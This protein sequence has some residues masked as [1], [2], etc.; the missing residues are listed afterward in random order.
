MEILETYIAPILGAVFTGVAFSYMV[1]GVSREAL[2][3]SDKKW[4]YYGSIVK[5]S[6]ILPVLIVIGLTVV[7]FIYGGNDEIYIEAMIFGFALVS[8]L[9][10][11]EFFNAKIGYDSDN[12]YVHSAWKKNRT[13]HWSEIISVKISK[14]SGVHTVVLRN[15]DKIEFNPLMSGV[16]E[17]MEEL[18]HRGI[19]NA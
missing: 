1:R 6:L 16:G 12:V 3:R 14:T 9:L 18:R 17:F 4:V 13:I 10:A 19:E 8:A 7:W 5:Y 15:S 2:D 11:L